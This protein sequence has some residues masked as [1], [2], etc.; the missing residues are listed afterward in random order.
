MHNA[1][2]DALLDPSVWPHPV[3]EVRLIETHISW[4][5]LAG[6]FAYKIKK[7]LDLGFLDFSTLEKRR[8]FC[9]EELRLNRRTAPALYLDM[10]PIAGSPEAPEIGGRDRPIEFAVRMR[11]FDAEATFDRLLRDGRLG[12]GDIDALAENLAELHR[13]AAIAPPD[14]RHGTF[15]AIAG[16]MRDNFTELAKWVDDPRLAQL[17]DWTGR[18]LHELNAEIERRRRDEFVRECHGDAHLGNVARIDGS[19][20]LFDCIE[21]APG[22]RWTDTICDLAFTVMDLSVRDADRLG[23]RLLDC[24]LARTGDFPGIRLL[25][26]YVVY[27]ALVRAKVSALRLSDDQADHDAVRADID[28]Y[29]DLAARTARRCRCALIVT[30]GYSGSGKSWLAER[31]VPE[32]GLIR[33]RSD[34]ERKRLYG[35]APGARGDH[36]V[37]QGLYSPEAGRRTYDRLAELARPVLQAG[38]PVLIDAACLKHAQRAHFRRLADALQVPFAM[39]WTSAPDELLR[40]R[41]VGRADRGDDPSDAGLDVLEH[42]RRTFEPPDRNEADAVFE[43]DT[44][45]PDSVQQALDAIEALLRAADGSAG[46]NATPRGGSGRRRFD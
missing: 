37:D 36:G 6:E 21:F 11:R 38:L 8:H 26:L 12:D 30:M 20:V 31:V 22:L 34:V 18:N 45:R 32:A 46:D 29:I 7:P 2:I 15:R 13:T 10:V 24:Y 19:A 5:L 17:R 25:P 1:L 35:L 3:D 44:S 4:V 28:R 14:T 40:E 39:L 43:I 9:E 27:R 33:I 16:P 42:Q 41:I 23:W